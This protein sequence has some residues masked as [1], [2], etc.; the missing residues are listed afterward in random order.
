MLERT[1]R[2]TCE[3]H[4]KGLTVHGKTLVDD[5]H[6]LRAKMARGDCAS[7]GLI[8]KSAPSHQ[9]N[10][11]TKAASPHEMMQHTRSPSERGVSRKRLTVPSPDGPM[12]YYVRYREEGS[13][14]SLRSRRTAVRRQYC[15]TRRLAAARRIYSWAAM[16]HSPDI[17]CSRGRD[18][19]GSASMLRVREWVARARM[20][21]CSGVP[22][23]R[24]DRRFGEF[25][26]CG[27]TPIIA[28]AVYH[29]GSEQAAEDASLRGDDSRFYVGKPSAALP[30]SGAR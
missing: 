13:T 19:K 25:T 8:R 18:E 26:T 15:S 12:A 3:T 28:L 20:P 29:H 7:T 6:G 4:P 24:L 1:P 10:E 5:T 14:R 2:P 9:E 21:T 23:R 27:A 11:Y 16:Q 30:I 17:G 22:T